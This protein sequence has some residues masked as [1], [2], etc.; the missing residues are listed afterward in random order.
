MERLQDG[1]GAG[2][3]VGAVRRQRPAIPEL[4][5]WQQMITQR[6][7]DIQ[8]A[9][10]AIGCSLQSLRGWLLMVAPDAG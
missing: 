5:R 8:T 2:G 10:R 1:A 4:Q 6:Q 3:G 9:A 7:V